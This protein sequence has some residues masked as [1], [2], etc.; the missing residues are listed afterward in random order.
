MSDQGNHETISERCRAGLL[1][2]LGPKR[3][4]NRLLATQSHLNRE[5]VAQAVDFFRSRK[6]PTSIQISSMADTATTDLLAREGFEADWQRCVLAAHADT[7]TGH[8][9]PAGVPLPAGVRVTRVRE[10]TVTDWLSV[11]AT[12]N[13]DASQHARATSDEFGLAARHVDGAVELLAS[14]DGHP[15]ACGS[16]QPVNGVG[17]LGGAATVST[18]RQRGLQGLLIDTRIQVASRAGLEI[19]AATATPGSSS[20]RNLE[21]AGLALSDVQ[22]VWTCRA[23]HGRAG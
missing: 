7:S 11:L 21:R 5:D 17:W 14:V 10:N 20:M 4:V 15:A 6:L 3:Y 13:E 12:S 23:S 1:V 19:V 8:R 9:L 16:L 22:T 18:F 2:S